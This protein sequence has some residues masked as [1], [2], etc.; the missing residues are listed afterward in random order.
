MGK[1]EDLR[2][3]PRFPA[4]AKADSVTFTECL[5]IGQAHWSWTSD[6]GPGHRKLISFNPFGGPTKGLPFHRCASRGK[7]VGPRALHW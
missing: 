2:M 5:D 3:I 7:I 6:I 4:Q 1:N